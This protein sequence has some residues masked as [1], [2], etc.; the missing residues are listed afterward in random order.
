MN[1][2]FFAKC[3][4]ADP[5]GLSDLQPGDSIHIYLHRVQLMWRVQ[6]PKSKHANQTKIVMNA[7]NPD[8]DKLLTVYV[9]EKPSEIYE[10][11]Q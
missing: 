11:A 5:A 4:V 3:T 8:T 10:Q 2:H 7:D 6:S 9:E 1:P